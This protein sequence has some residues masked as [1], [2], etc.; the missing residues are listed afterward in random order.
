MNG[1]G[2]VL[3]DVTSALQL[4]LLVTFTHVEVNLE[5]KEHFS[6]VFS[7][8]SPCTHQLTCILGV[9]LQESSQAVIPLIL[10][11]PLG[12]PRPEDFEV[13]SMCTAKVS[14]R[15]LIRATLFDVVYA[16]P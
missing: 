15:T 8:V 5:W 12:S 13:C 10:P 11:A 9:E 3:L 2:L 4:D 7:P 6:T 14:A 1:F 16:K